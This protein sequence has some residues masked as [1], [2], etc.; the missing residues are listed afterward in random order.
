MLGFT[1]LIDEIVNKYDLSTA[2]VF[3]VA[4]RFCQ[5]QQQVGYVSLAKTLGLT[6]RCITNHLQKLV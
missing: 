1:P 5:Q 2:A 6:P 4:W 3:G